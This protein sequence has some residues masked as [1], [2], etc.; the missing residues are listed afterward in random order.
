[1]KLYFNKH[2]LLHPVLYIPR[3]LLQHLAGGALRRVAPALE[4]LAY[5][6]NRHVDAKLDLDEIAHGTSAPQ[7]KRQAPCG[8]GA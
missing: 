1:M 5:R 3:L 7:D 8:V 4:L 2:N 6:A